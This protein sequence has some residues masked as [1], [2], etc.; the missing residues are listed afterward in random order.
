MVTLWNP[1][2]I[3]KFN[4]TNN[5]QK[6]PHEGLENLTSITDNLQTEIDEGFID[7]ANELQTEMNT[8]FENLKPL[9]TVCIEFWLE[10]QQIN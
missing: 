3:F 4:V 10:I 5:L 7:L 6:E 9:S 2:R 1:W 8:K